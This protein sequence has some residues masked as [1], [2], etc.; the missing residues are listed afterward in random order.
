MADVIKPTFGGSGSGGGEPPP[1]PPSYNELMFA[2]EQQRD[3]VGHLRNLMI[4]REEENI[5]LKKACELLLTQCSEMVKLLD[6]NAKV[7]AIATKNLK[8]IT[9]YLKAT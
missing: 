7:A 4:T 9:T 5:R 8:E 6:H 1:P 3:L 2:L